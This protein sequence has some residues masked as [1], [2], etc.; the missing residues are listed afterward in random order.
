MATTKVRVSRC[1]YR[2][3]L[4]GERTATEKISAAVQPRVIRYAFPQQTENN[5]IAVLSLNTGAPKF[6]DFRPSPLKLRELKLLFTIISV[7]GRSVGAGLKPIGTDH[8]PRRQV[9]NQQVITDGVELIH[10]QAGLEGLLQSFIQF[11]VENLKAETLSLTHLILSP[12]EAH[13]VMVRAAD[14][15]SNR[16]N[17]VSYW[18]HVWSE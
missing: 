13:S 5:K 18:V 1:P 12:R 11:N 9:L 7:V 2:W 8:L 14:K 3:V 4:G 15:E 17:R 10:V 16:L 6:N